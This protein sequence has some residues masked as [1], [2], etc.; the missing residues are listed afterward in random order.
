MER[1]IALAPLS[2]QLVDLKP[3]LLQV[4]TRLS[5]GQSGRSA[6]AWKSM[7]SQ[8]CNRT[9]VS[10]YYFEQQ[11]ELPPMLRHTHGSGMGVP[12]R[13]RGMTEGPLQGSMA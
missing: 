3:E 11:R 9:N 13:E 6:A 10:L 5:V 8:F 4:G 1:A 2:R 12:C 7:F